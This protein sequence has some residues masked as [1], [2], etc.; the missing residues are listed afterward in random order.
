MVFNMRKTL[1]T[2]SKY[3]NNVPSKTTDF[4]IAN[5]L[6]VIIL[7]ATEGWNFAAYS[8]AEWLELD[9]VEIADLLREDTK[10]V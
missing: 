5:T 8:K 2:W 10:D 1:K 7:W 4:N 3:W 9:F 6:D